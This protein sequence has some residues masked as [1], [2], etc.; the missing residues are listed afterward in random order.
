LN[1]ALH[2]LR[3]L[4]PSGRG[5]VLVLREEVGEGMKGGDAVKGFVAWI[6]YVIAFPFLRIFK[7]DELERLGDIYNT[8][9]ICSVFFWLSAVA[10][11]VPN[12]FINTAL[13]GGSARPYLLLYL[14]LLVFAVFVL[15]VATKR[16]V[17][18]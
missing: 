14:S 16:E 10:Q 13:V 1:G 9:M 3:P 4:Q 18:T 12:E 17:P 2:L 6:Y 11:G 5:L 15:L 7:K 8:V